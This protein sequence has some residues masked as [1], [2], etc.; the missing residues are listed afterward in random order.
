MI[1][2]DSGR[3]R[4]KSENGKKTT[5]ILNRPSRWSREVDRWQNKEPKNQHQGEDGSPQHDNAA[6]CPPFSAF[7]AFVKQEARIACNP[8]ISGKVQR[9]QENKREDVERT[10]EGNKYPRQETALQQARMKIRKKTD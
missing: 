10:G 4:R 1:P 8:V 9:E 6:I 7:C 2:K 5:L 3:P